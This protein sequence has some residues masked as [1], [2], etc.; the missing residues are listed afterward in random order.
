MAE[1]KLEDLIN[2]NKIAIRE[3]AKHLE[4]NYKVYNNYIEVYNAIEDKDHGYFILLKEF[5]EAY[6]NYQV[7]YEEIEEKEFGGAERTEE[8]NSKLQQ[9]ISERNRIRKLLILALQKN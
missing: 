3:V 1:I 5:I 2:L 7:Y 6:F 8:E 4:I 9:L